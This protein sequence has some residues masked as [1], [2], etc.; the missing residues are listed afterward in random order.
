VTDLQDRLSVSLQR[1]QVSIC[2]FQH[3]QLQNFMA[4]IKIEH[5]MYN[6]EIRSNYS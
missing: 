4:L 1:H 2:L 3:V 6:N 5:A